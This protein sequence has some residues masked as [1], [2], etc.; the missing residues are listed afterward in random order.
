MPNTRP[1]EQQEHLPPRKWQ[2]GKFVVFRFDLEAPFE[3]Q[4]KQL[5]AIC[6]ELGLPPDDDAPAK[7]SLP[8]EEPAR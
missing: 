1:P 7:T 2:G 8:D 4:E 6:D 5:D 3:E